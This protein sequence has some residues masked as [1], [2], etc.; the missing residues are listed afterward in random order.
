MHFHP[1]TDAVPQGIYYYGTELLCLTVLSAVF[2]LCNRFTQ[3]QNSGPHKNTQK[4]LQAEI[5]EAHQKFQLLNAKIAELEQGNADLQEKLGHAARDVKL[6]ESGCHWEH[7][8]NIAM[9]KKLACYERE[10]H[11]KTAQEIL[12]GK[13]GLVGM[14]YQSSAIEQ[15]SKKA[16]RD[17]PIGEPSQT[18]MRA[19]KKRRTFVSAVKKAPKYKGSEISKLKLSLRRK[20]AD[21]NN[22]ENLL[23]KNGNQAKLQDRRIQENQEENAL[24]V[25]KFQS[26]G[27]T[28]LCAQNVELANAPKK[29]QEQLQSIEELQ[30]SLEEKEGQLMDLAASSIDDMDDNGVSGNNPAQDQL[31]AQIEALRTAIEQRKATKTAES[32]LFP[33]NVDY[34]QMDLSGMYRYMSSD[35][36]NDIG[37]EWQQDAL[38]DLGCIE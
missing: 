1:S 15:N 20:E 33:S 2:V 14:R 34:S 4:I 30:K 19:E 38:H 25:K 5:D 11:E 18:A 16:K 22:M 9:R 12:K 36:T 31:K 21:C 7:S 32:E 8:A 28:G 27:V 13:A 10:R 35:C 6:A 17:L 23:L 24:I 29:C 3:L 26:N 37:D